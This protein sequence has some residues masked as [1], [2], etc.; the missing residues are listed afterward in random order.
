MSS[1]WPMAATASAPFSRSAP[2]PFCA[3]TWLCRHSQRGA[4]QVEVA[5]VRDQVGVRAGGGAAA[6]G[7]GAALGGASGALAPASSSA[8]FAF[9]C[10]ARRGGGG[11]DTGEQDQG[12]QERR[13]QRTDGH[14]DL[15]GNWVKRPSL[16]P[17]CLVHESF[18]SPAAQR[19]PWLC[20]PSSRTV[21]PFGSENLVTPYRRR[22]FSLKRSFGR[23]SD[24]EQTGLAEYLRRV[25]LVVQ[26]RQHALRV[27]V[28]A[29]L[30]HQLD[31]GLAHVQVQPFADVADVD[32]VRAGAGDGGEQ[33]REPARAVRDAGERD[34]PAP[35]LG[36]VA[37]GDRR[38]QAASMLPPE[39]TATVVPPSAGLTCPPSIAA[40]PTAPAPSTTSLQRSSSSAIASAVAS[41]STTTISSRWVAGSRS[42]MPPGRLT[43]MPSAIVSADVASI[44]SPGCHRLRVRRA[45][46]GLDADDLHVRLGVLDHERDARRTARRRRPGS[47]PARGRARPRATR[48]R[49]SPARR[50]SRDRRTGARTRARPP[51]R[52]RAR[53]PGRRRRCCR[54]RG[55]SRP[56]RAR[57][58]P[59]TSARRWGRRPRTGCR[60]RPRRRR[61]PGRGCRRW[62]RRRR[63]RALLAQR[64][65]L[66]GHAA[67]LER[68]GPLQVLGLEHDRP[69]RTLGE[70]AGGE[71]RRAARDGLAPPRVRPGRRAR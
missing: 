4:D 17:T 51:R 70:R 61:A 37:A 29:R 36:L 64:G 21:C 13:E 67:D 69:T 7:L 5:G 10:L 45:R 27:L 60:G 50:R 1:E 3:R 24:A 16:H 28:P 54:R 11:V 53:R 71:D 6:G 58:R 19:A 39:S 49:A 40:T 66:R 68:A 22:T 55:R 12:E 9:G 38:Q 25:A 20:A 47:R 42:G 48:A 31:R 34:Q 8:T 63:W 2:R 46:G 15:Q 65:E 30:Q 18:G 26:R 43:A 57:P 33:R 59:W 56:A 44:G 62:R 41:S 32:D 35:G 52:A 23:T 14:S